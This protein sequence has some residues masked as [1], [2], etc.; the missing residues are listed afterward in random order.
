MKKGVLY[1]Q[2]HE[3]WLWCCLTTSK[4]PIML[5]ELHEGVRGGYFVSNI[6]IKKILAIGY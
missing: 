2:G 6:K 1:K 3:N 5:W 4:I